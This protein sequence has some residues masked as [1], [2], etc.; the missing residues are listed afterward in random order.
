[1]SGFY[2]TGHVFYISTPLAKPFNSP[3]GASINPNRK[4]FP[5]SRNIPPQILLPTGYFQ[6]ITLL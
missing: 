3:G 5:A 2:T 4:F 6:A 1:M